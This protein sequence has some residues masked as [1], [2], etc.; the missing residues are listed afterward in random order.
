MKFVSMSLATFVF[1]LVFASGTSAQTP[2]SQIVIKDWCDMPLGLEFSPNGRVLARKCFGYAVAFF[3]TSNYH[4]AR[5]FLSE[6]EHTPELW[7]FAYSPDGTMIATAQGSSGARIWN[8]AD[9]G[10][11]RPKGFSISVKEKSVWVMGELYTWDAPLRILQPPLHGI[12]ERGVSST[13]FSPDGKRLLTVQTNQV[14]VWNTTSWI[15]E[16]ELIPDPDQRLDDVFFSP[17]GKLLLTSLENG[18]IKI[19]NVSSWTIEGEFIVSNRQPRVVTFA[20]D[21]HSVMIGDLDGVLHQWSLAAKTEIRTLRTFEG[22]GR[23]GL[24]GSVAFSADGKTLVATSLLAGLPVIVWDTTNWNA[25]TEREY[26]SAAFS[27]DG[28]LL[29]LGG[30][31]HIKLVE[32]VTQKLVR[33]V[34]FPEITR[35]EVASPDENEPNPNEKIP[36]Y[37]FSALAFSPDG[38]TLAAGCLI[39]EPEQ[40]RMGRGGVKHGTDYG[41]IFITRALS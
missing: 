39:Y 31:N 20:P 34:E 37:S 6:L 33:D 3:D 7:G 5:T 1:V 12:H 41:V 25:R 22:P 19:W 29:A 8:V 24:L 26:K 18:H 35:G 14:K 15:T 9:P 11:P 2:S 28:K 17:D 32:P 30:H 38:N 23:H 16:K 40:L 4:I 27:K 21:S 10:K 36:C 13:K